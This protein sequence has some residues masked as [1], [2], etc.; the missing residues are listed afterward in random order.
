MALRK[1]Y[2][3]YQS[4]SASCNEYFEMMT[5][6]IDVISHFGGFIGNHPF[7]VDKFLKAADLADPDNPTENET[8]ATKTATEE[9]YMATAFP[10]G[11]NK[12]KYRVLINELHHNFNMGR[13]EYPKT[14]TAAY[15]LAINWKGGTKGPSVIPNDHV[16]F[17]TESEEADVHATDGMKMTWSGNPFI[18]H[19]CGN[20]HYANMCPEREESAPEKK[21]DKVKDTPNKE[22]ALSKA[23]VN[24]GLYG[25]SVPIRPQ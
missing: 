12:A 7:L 6:L 4:S 8:A 21:A 10:S 9:A 15:D 17:T 14:F 23:S 16:A 13:E 25:H 2:S 19:I 11:L 5:N 22:S 3:S 18:W 24:V 20:N 1:F